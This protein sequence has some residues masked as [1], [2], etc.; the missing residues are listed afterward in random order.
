[1]RGG[2]P[3]STIVPMGD[4]VMSRMPARGR[5]AAWD[6][7]R[8]L[9]LVAAVLAVVLA[10]GHPRTPDPVRP[11]AWQPVAQGAAAVAAME[12]L[13]PP[14]SF[15]WVATSARVEPQPDGTVVWRCGFLTPSGAYAGLLQRGAFPDQAAQAQREWVQ[16]ETRRGVAQGVVSI[17]GRDWVRM[18]GDPSPD[19]RRSLVNE[20]DGTSTLVTG[21][22]T[23]AELEELAGALSPAAG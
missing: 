4:E 17:G 22:A 8:S 14:P 10:I 23:W 20:Q 16:A 9:G 1:M 7:A 18:V 13:A 2:R 21:S 12:V 19:E 15:S 3:W 6:M 11:I 5:H